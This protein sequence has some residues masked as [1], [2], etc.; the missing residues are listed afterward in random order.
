MSH[1]R[2]PS[3]IDVNAQT[4]HSHRRRSSATPYSPLTPRSNHGRRPSSI[5]QNFHEHFEHDSSIHENVIGGG[6]ASNGLGSLADELADA[7]DEDEDYDEE[8]EGGGYDST[9]SLQSP[10]NTNS[11]PQ[12]DRNS[13]TGRNSLEIPSSPPA[14]HPSTHHSNDDANL[15]SPSTASTTTRANN[16]SSSARHRRQRSVYDGSD[17]G[18]SS[19]LETTEGI[20]PGLEAKMAAV[21]GLVRRGME[22]N[23]S[24]S[25]GVVGRVID[26]LKDLG[27]QVGVEGG[28]TR[29]AT[30]HHSLTT[31]LTH[32]TRLLASLTSTLL[33]PLSLPFLPSDLLDPLAPLLASLPPSLPH[34]S[35]QPLPALQA[36]A[37]T[38]NSLLASLAACADALQLSR[39]T[40]TSAGRSLRAAQQRLAELQAEYTAAE[41]GRA[42]VEEG[43][44]EERLKGREC[45]RECREVVGGFEEVCAGWRARLEEAAAAGG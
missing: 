13:R 15:L 42:W 26:G 43:G 32:Q 23:G 31:H 25:D 4:P 36:L 33:S 3:S 8:E 40:A 38:T 27:G 12:H 17:Y 44:W 18:D 20:S 45:A 37:H 21:E 5:D 6:A 39:Q 1:R 24:A 7:E 19:D 41:K 10:T 35:P 34:P 9:Q 28:T 30:A 16:R 11:T 14:A 22:E 2:R 29:L